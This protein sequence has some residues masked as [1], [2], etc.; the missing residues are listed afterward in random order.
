MSNVLNW[1]LLTSTFVKIQYLMIVKDI[2]R[3]ID[4]RNLE[5]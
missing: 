3:K 5:M 4:I 1:D 2:V